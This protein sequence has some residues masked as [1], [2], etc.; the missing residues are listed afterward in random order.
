VKT[1]PN[2]NSTGRLTRR[3]SRYIDHHLLVSV[4]LPTM[5]KVVDSAPETCSWD[6]TST[7]TLPVLDY[8]VMHE[9]VHVQIK[10]HSKRF[11]VKLK[12]LIPDYRQNIE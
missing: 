5:L 10:T 3:L 6:C 2:I 12:V 11:W 8:V 7:S 4:D 9:L 1:Q